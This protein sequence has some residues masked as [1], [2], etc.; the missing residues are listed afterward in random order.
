MANGKM[1]TYIFLMKQLG[2]GCDYT[3]ACGYD[4]WECKAESPEKA[5]ELFEIQEGPGFTGDSS[6]EYIYILE[7]KYIKKIDKPKFSSQADYDD[8]EI[9]KM[10]NEYY[11]LGKLL[12]QIEAI[13]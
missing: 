1:K 12:K 10:L 4:W 8:D 6:L 13:Y 5:W 9:E 7:T 2:G 11:R 3:I